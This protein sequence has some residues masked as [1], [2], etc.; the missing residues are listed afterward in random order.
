MGN[1]FKLFFGFAFGWLVP[2]LPKQ[3]IGIDVTKANTDANVPV[4]YGRGYGAGLLVYQA[5]NDADSDDIKNDLLHQVIVWGEGQCGGITTN[6]VD[7]EESSSSRFTLPG[8]RVYHAR[9]FTNGIANFNDPLFTA[10]G[11]RSTDTFNGKL[12]SYVRC[13]MVPDVWQGQPDHKAEWTGRLI[14]TPSGGALTASEN[15]SSQ[16]Y[17]LLKSDVYGKGLLTSKLSVSSF[18]TAK[19]YCDT[20]VEKFPGSGTSRKLF[21]SNVRLDTSNTVLDNVNTLLRSMRGFLFHSDGKLKL[22]IEKD[23]APVDFSLDENEKGFIQWGDISNSSKSN[24]Y[25]RVIC[26]YTDPDSGWTKQEAIYP[27]PGS[28]REA[29]LLAEDNG[30]ILEKSITL[31]TC[32]YYNEAHKHASTILEVSRQQLRTSI[33]WG[34]EASILE[35]G[36]ILPAYRLSTGWAGKLFRIESVEKSLSTGEVSLRLREHQPYIYDDQNTGDKP[37]LPDTTITYDRPATPTNLSVSDVYNDFSQVVITWDSSTTD[38][39]IVITGSDNNQLVNSQISG[40]SFSINQFKIDTYSLR[41]FALG[42]LGRRSLAAILS[43]DI[44][45]RATDTNSPVIIVTPGE[46]L[47]TPPKPLAL[48]DIYEGVYTTNSNLDPNSDP[49]SSFIALADGRSLNIPSPADGQTYYLWYRLKTIQGLGVWLMIEVTG[50][51]LNETN[52]SNELQLKIEKDRKSI[53]ELELDIPNVVADRKALR[54]FQLDVPNI[55][56]NINKTNLELINLASGKFNLE[57]EYSERLANNDRL[58]DASVYIDQDTGVIINRAFAFTEKSFSQAEI[59]IDGVNAKIDLEVEKVEVLDKKIIA[60]DAAIVLQAGEI[61]QRATYSE[62]STEIA[63]ALASL[64]PVYSWQFNNDKE[65]YSGVTHDTR[66][67]VSCTASSPAVAP[68]VEYTSEEYPTFKMLVRLREGGTWNGSVQSNLGAT[69]VPEPSAEDVWE[70]RTVKST[71]T[72]TVTSL[73][74]D[75]GD[76]DIDYIE[77][78]KQGANDIA[79]EDL[80]GRVTV[81][82]STLSAIDGEYITS[83]ITTWYDMGAVINSDVAFQIDSFDSKAGITATLQELDTEGTIAKASSAQLWVDAAS[84]T[85]TA[86]IS[87]FNQEQGITSVTQELNAVRGSITNQALAI[88]GL[89]KEYTVFGLALVDQEY[90]MHLIRNDLET[91]DAVIALANSETRAYI[92]DENTAIAERTTALIA[93][94][95]EKSQ[96]SIDILEQSRANDKLAQTILNTSLKSSI[97]LEGTLR[98]SSIDSISTTISDDKKAQAVISDNLRSSIEEEGELRTASIESVSGTIATKE[99]AQ[100]TINDTLTS[101]IELEGET[102]L[103][104]IKTVNETIVNQ[105]AAQATVSNNLLSVITRNG[106]TGSDL[107]LAQ[108]DQEY[109]AHLIRNDLNTGD[110][111]IALANSR[112][113]TYVD[114]ENTSYAE[115]VTELMARSGQK[116]QA[117]VDILT[118]AISNETFARA[119]ELKTYKAEVVTD[120][121]TVTASAKE[122]TL[123]TVG[124][125]VVNGKVNGDINKGQCDISGGE[126]R[127]LPLSEAMDKVQVTITNAD[128][129]TTTANSGTYFQVL[130]NALGTLEANAFLGVNVDGEVTGVTASDGTPLGSTLTL[131]G[132]SIK[133]VAADINAAPFVEYDAVNNHAIIRGQLILGDGKVINNNEDIKAEDGDTIFEIYRYSP[134]G[135]SDFNSDLRLTDYFRQTAVVT[136]GN[137]ANWSDSVRIRID[138]YSPVKGVDYDDGINGNNVIVQYNS[139][140]VSTGWTVHYVGGHKW[141][142]TSVDDGNGNFTAGNAA[143]FIPEEGVEYTVKDGVSSYLHIK[144]SD[145]NETFTADNGE[146]L[147]IYIGT[148]V[149]NTL[150][151]SD[152][153]S[154]YKFRKYIGDKGDTP[155]VGSDFYVQDGSFKSFVFKTSASKP[156]SPTGGSFNGSD[157]TS[158]SGWRDDP[159]FTEGQITWVSSALYTHT[160]NDD[161]DTWSNAG[162]STPAEY[163]KKGEDNLQYKIRVK[164]GTVLK[165]GVG[166]IE[167]RASAISGSLQGDL[168]EGDIRL[169]NADTNQDFQF[170]E[171]FSANGAGTSTAV[172]GFLN[173]V[174]KSASTGYIY[175]SVTLTNV[176]DGHNPV[177]GED[178]YVQDGSFRSFIFK[179]AASIPTGDDLATGGSFNGTTETSPTGWKDNPYF[180]ENQTTWVSSTFYVHTNN[181]DEDT[182]SNTGWSAPAEYSKKGE[183]GRS[184]ATIEKDGEQVTISYDDGSPDD[185]FTVENGTSPTPLSVTSVVKNGLNTTVTLSDDAGSSFI[186]TDGGAGRGIDTVTK[187]GET[188]TVTFDD[189]SPN[190]TFTVIDGASGSGWYTIVGN[191]GLFPADSVAT[192]EFKDKTGRPPIQD[193]HLTYVNDDNSVSSVKRFTGSG[194]SAPTLVINGDLLTKGTVSADRIVANTEIEAPTIT[195]GKLQTSSEDE[196][197][198]TIVHDDGTYALWI[199][200]GAKT[201]AN[202]TFHIKKNGEGFIKGEF[203]QG[204]ISRERSKVDTNGKSATATGHKSAGRTVEVTGSFLYAMSFYSGTKKQPLSVTFRFKRGTTVIESGTFPVQ[205]FQEEEDRNFNGQ[206]SLNLGITTFDENTVDGETYAYTFEIT[207]NL[208]YDPSQTLRTSVKTYE[209]LI[210]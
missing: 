174:L 199:G 96:A 201:D 166:S 61:N 30:V 68:D 109:F 195:G 153:F 26:R 165:N 58:I 157:E 138:G 176:L 82:E 77:V 41:L 188:V 60:S 171:Y 206:Y 143:K 119:L 134:D 147:G 44:T 126:W 66:G 28:E 67:Y 20:N 155:V 80:V 33:I 13:E 84:E 128:G 122:F 175:D 53:E 146:T 107:E 197:F 178:Y 150:K 187:N 177:R 191:E 170:T 14:S 52:F 186:I 87:S 23:D 142:R 180:T 27:E 17:D 169:F 200:E 45:I 158:P 118:Q 113:R 149:D 79:L 16:L 162:W 154:R 137:A 210:G 160:N 198:R 8:G 203:F 71:D 172:D 173:V 39:Q 83:I 179:T 9:N 55:Q 115:E 90:Y 208:P 46:I 110:A 112:L 37:E 3:E 49:L 94:G 98:E 22:L 36:D 152:V 75:L 73:E 167:L 24:R 12:V 43:F 48:I 194:W 101:S 184:V 97:E 111:V 57:K 189:D 18:Q 76:V 69:P 91:G 42:G 151:D 1:P 6:F 182:W 148:Y 104:S 140:N 4:L 116:S 88:G 95:G 21:T 141:I 50:H 35:V 54:S 34:P 117:S 32:I 168:T 209:N 31:D 19:N 74:F 108:L 106:K 205:L 105:E 64:T 92:D 190:Q 99:A 51:G 131:R 164:N 15:P 161:E 100:A 63:G 202:S 81:A 102:R 123:A 185:T 86:A 127:Q 129:T 70:V 204:Q 114:D 193:D 93:I 207:T 25:N 192:Q 139:E 29:E 136:N 85:I 10:S 65:N 11:K 183:A 62:L 78:A 125:C 120:L 181:K 40:K 47:V 38:H 156:S 121:E 124:Y 103:A 72:G 163:S 59:L 144:Y 159:Y 132:D 135:T 2:E 7:D 5:T 145:D 133:L 89:G 130:Q 56:D 196:D